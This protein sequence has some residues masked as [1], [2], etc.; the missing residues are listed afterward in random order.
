MFGRK[1]L[2]D[3]SR[4]A[5]RR[6]WRER[7]VGN[8]RVGIHRAL[9]G[10]IE[11]QG[12]YE[13]LDGIRL[14]TLVMVGD[15]DIATPPEKAARIAGHIPGARLVTI[16]GAGHTVTVEEPEAVNRCLAEFLDDPMGF[17]AAGA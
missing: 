2:E 1:S 17:R 7:L 12:V 15:Q 14:P 6:E 10:V 9:L 11:R 16:P 13:E 3:P 4:E 5:E 8:H